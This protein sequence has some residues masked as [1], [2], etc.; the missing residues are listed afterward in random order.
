MTTQGLVAALGDIGVNLNRLATI[1]EGQEVF[2]NL[3]FQEI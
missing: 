2:A 1:R 3:V